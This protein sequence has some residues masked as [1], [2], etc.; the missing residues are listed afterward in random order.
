MLKNS[1]ANK[2]FLALEDKKQELYQQQP[3]ATSQLAVVLSFEARSELHHDE[4]A[5][6][7]FSCGKPPETV[8]G[9]KFTVEEQQEPFM[10]E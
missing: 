8:F 10:L 4:N 5:M 1:L 7:I 9:Y 3:S 6:V 2:L